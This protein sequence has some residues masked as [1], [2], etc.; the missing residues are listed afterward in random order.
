MP[1]A[2]TPPGLA[3]L[4][5]GPQRMQAG[6]TPHCQHR[7][8]L[9]VWDQH[10]DRGLAAR[11]ET[12]PGTPSQGQA[13]GCPWPGP[14]RCQKHP[15]WDNPSIGVGTERSRLG[16]TAIISSCLPRSANTHACKYLSNECSNL[17]LAAGCLPHQ[18][19]NRGPGPG[20]GYGHMRQCV[21]AHA[22]PGVIRVLSETPIREPSGLRA[23]RGHS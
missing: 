19:D 4:S 9:R 5:V 7:P 6:R 10:Q 2:W 3:L 8:G 20:L 18:C 15:S 17:G 16:S 21:G 1:A 12:R 14:T 11:V 13:Q 22:N 23:G